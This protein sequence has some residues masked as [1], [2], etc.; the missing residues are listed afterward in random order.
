MVVPSL[1]PLTIGKTRR[2]WLGSG[3]DALDVAGFARP[4]TRPEF[5]WG[6]NAVPPNVATG[7]ETSGSL[8]SLGRKSAP[9]REAAFVHEFAHVLQETAAPLSV[10]GDWVTAGTEGSARYIEIAAGV[11]DTYFTDSRVKE[12]INSFG[13]DAFSNDRLREKE[14]WL[15]YE[16]A[17]SYYQFVADTGGSSWQLALDRG[18]GV[19]LPLRA[20]QQGAQFSAENWRKWVDSR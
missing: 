1:N 6:T 20:E 14:A 9:I 5:T 17:G 13:T 4:T 12:R 16:A 8:V 10:R 19:T 2:R 3:Y 18:H 11:A 15:A 7:S